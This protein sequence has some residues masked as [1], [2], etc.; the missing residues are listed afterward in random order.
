MDI[1]VFTIFG[2]WADKNMLLGCMS[3]IGVESPGY[4]EGVAEMGKNGVKKPERG[5]QK[6]SR[7]AQG[8]VDENK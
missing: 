1:I 4:K 6:D 8:V 2:S 3:Q 7:S 5:V